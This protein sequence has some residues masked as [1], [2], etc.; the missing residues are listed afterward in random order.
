MNKVGFQT[1]GKVCGLWIKFLYSPWSACLCTPNP[2]WEY[3]CLICHEFP[4]LKLL[5]LEILV[6]LIL[7]HVPFGSLVC[8]NKLYPHFPLA[9]FSAYNTVRQLAT[10]GLKKSNDY[11]WTLRTFSTFEHDDLCFLRGHIFI[12]H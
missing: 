7:L 5:T 8:K 1:S 4:S 10:N 9:V 3:R 11:S 2:L 12:I 6:F